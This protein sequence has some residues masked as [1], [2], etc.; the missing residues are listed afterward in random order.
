VKSQVT[1]HCVCKHICLAEHNTEEPPPLKLPELVDW[2]A[3]HAAEGPYIDYKR[4]TIRDVWGN[5]VVVVSE[6]GK[7]TGLGSAGPDGNWQNGAG[8]DIVVTLEEVK[9]R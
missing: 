7:L 3:K 1:L 2:L 8:D 5:P 4:K 9:N 6:S